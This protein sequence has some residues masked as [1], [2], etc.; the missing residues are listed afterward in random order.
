VKQLLVGGWS[1]IVAQYDG[2]FV[3]PFGPRNT[4]ASTTSIFDRK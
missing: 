1:A 3:S 4:V 2:V